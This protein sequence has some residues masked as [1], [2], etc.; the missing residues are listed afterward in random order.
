MSE[1]TGM[2]EWTRRRAEDSVNKR[3]AEEEYYTQK[4][5]NLEKYMEIMNVDLKLRD[6]EVLRKK[7]VANRFKCPFRGQVW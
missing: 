6:E 7:E 4:T 1:D 2:D 5:K 3:E